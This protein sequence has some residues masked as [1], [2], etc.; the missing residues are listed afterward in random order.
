MSRP[1]P[2]VTVPAS[3]GEL[4]G[5]QAEQR[6][7]AGAVRPD[8]ADPVAAQD[9]GREVADDGGGRRSSC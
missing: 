5:Q 6:R 7:L 4:A 8:D 3:G 9:A 2:S 1:L